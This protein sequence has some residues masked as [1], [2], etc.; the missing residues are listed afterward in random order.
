MRTTIEEKRMQLSGVA[1]STRLLRAGEGPPVLLLHGS[2]DSAT[3]WRPVMERLASS[4]L[5]LAPDLPGLG[6][7]DEPP[8]SFDFSREAAGAFLDDVLAAAGVREPVVL[9]VH[10][11]GGIF[12]VPWAAKH[13]DRIRG[14]VITNTVVFEDFPWFGTA[15]LFSGALGPAVTWQMG[16][17]GGRLFRAGFKRISPELGDE[18]ID[19]MT[20][21]FA[22]DGKSKRS[23]LRLFRKMVPPAYFSGMNAAVSELVAR[24]PARVLWG[25]GDPY[26]S[27]EY[28]NRFPGAKVERLEKAGHWVPLSAPDAVAAAVRS[29]L[30]PSSR[31]AA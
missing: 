2:P 19:R 26:I 9:V 4:S 25:S 18:D 21:E 11:I 20:R 22:C 27:S 13:L 3:E 16:W 29:V 14:V 24:V 30:A 12:G 15:K 5:C 23:T 6:A 10:D 31:S 28:A 7:C 1:M 17:F 8:A